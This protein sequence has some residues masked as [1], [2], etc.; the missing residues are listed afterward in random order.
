MLQRLQ[1]GLALKRQVHPLQESAAREA[2]H[3]RQL[4]Q[5]AA[6]RQ[7]RLQ[8]PK[9]RRQRPEAQVSEPGRHATAGSQLALR[10]KKGLKSRNNQRFV[11]QRSSQGFRE[12][13]SGFLPC[14]NQPLA[15]RSTAAV[16]AGR[17][18]TPNSHITPEARMIPDTNKNA[19]CMFMWPPM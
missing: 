8:K 5:A 19:M 10:Q 12:S 14:W 16:S 15:L 17:Y 4:R 18:F 7:D 11:R 2:G 9:N 6:P 3:E 13:L 1:V